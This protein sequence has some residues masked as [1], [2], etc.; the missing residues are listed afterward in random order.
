MQSIV[1]ESQCQCQ[2][3]R[4]CIG[5]FEFHAFCIEPQPKLLVDAQTK[6]F[7]LEAAQSELDV[8]TKHR[9]F[10]GYLDEKGVT[11]AAVLNG[12]RSHS[13]V[14]IILYAMQC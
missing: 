2:Q 10:V 9:S 5:P 6:S 7:Q 12:P 4:C 1:L 8:M 11:R 14:N 3:C 13:L